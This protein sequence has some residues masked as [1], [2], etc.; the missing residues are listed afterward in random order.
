MTDGMPSAEACGWLHQLQICKLLQHKDMV[1]CL[2]GLNSELAALLFTYPELPL[3]DAATH[4]K[5]AHE[6]QLIEVDL[7]NMQPVSITTVP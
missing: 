1:V 4:G 3:W 2:E 7:G 5:P 6:P